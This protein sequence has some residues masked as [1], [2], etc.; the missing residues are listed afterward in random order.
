MSKEKQR[1]HLRKLLKKRFEHPSKWLLFFV[2][3]GSLDVIFLLFIVHTLLVFPA[4]NIGTWIV[5]FVL[6]WGLY[7]VLVLSGIHLFSI[8][9]YMTLN[10]PRGWRLVA[11]VAILAL[12]IGLLLKYNFAEITKGI[13]EQKTI[14]TA[15]KISK[16]TALR[17]LN[18]CRIDYLSVTQ[19]YGAKV[20]FYTMA[21]E[22]QPLKIVYLKEDEIREVYQVFKAKRNACAREVKIFNDRTIDVGE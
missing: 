18:E 20:S 8:V 11:S 16:Q 22:R 17:L 1:T 5:I 2:A 7:V 10:R 14:P 19:L 9:I 21:P 4:L 15:S 6:K 13:I 3:L 12:S